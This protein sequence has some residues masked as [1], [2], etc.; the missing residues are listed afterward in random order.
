[1]RLPQ[2]LQQENSETS[3]SKL[4]KGGFH[5]KSPKRG[6]TNLVY[7]VMED[8]FEKEVKSK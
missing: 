7:K 3:L 6:S 5:N 1:M 2:I 4:R 8:K